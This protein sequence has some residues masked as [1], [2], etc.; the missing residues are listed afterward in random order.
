MVLGNYIPGHLDSSFIKNGECCEEGLWTMPPGKVASQVKYFMTAD[1][2]LSVT[3][4]VWEWRIRRIR[5]R[6][7]YFLKVICFNLNLANSRF[8]KKGLRKKGS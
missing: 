2:G 3:Q 4:F 1:H 7:T 6:G 5:K 8:N